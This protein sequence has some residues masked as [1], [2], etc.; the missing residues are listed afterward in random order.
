MAEYLE[1]NFETD[2]RRE[3]RF[4]IDLKGIGRF[5]DPNMSLS[6]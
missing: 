2:L 5:L 6:R 4:V 3:I 1:R